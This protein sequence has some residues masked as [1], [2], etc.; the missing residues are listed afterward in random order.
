MQ[1][2]ITGQDIDMNLF[3]FIPG[4]TARFAGFPV[5]KV[6]AGVIIALCVS[7]AGMGWYLKAK[8]AETGRLQERV[9][10]LTQTVSEEQRKRR[11]LSTAVLDKVMEFE[12][13]QIKSQQIQ[14][15][16]I[17]QLATERAKS[18]QSMQDAD[19]QRAAEREKAIQEGRNHAEPLF[20]I[21]GL[22]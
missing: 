17:A 8:I 4:L 12:Q 18:Q 9:E 16:L 19:A 2:G 3:G 6:M 11:S 5:I 13:A 7:L 20:D 22:R 21:R 15:N 1:V 14:S 10:Q